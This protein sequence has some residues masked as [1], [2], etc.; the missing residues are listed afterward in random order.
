MSDTTGEKEIEEFYTQN[1]DVNYEKFKNI[2]VILRQRDDFQDKIR[3][4]EDKLKFHLENQSWQKRDLVNILSDFL[5][6]MHHNEVG[7]SLDDKM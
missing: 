2:G 3:T 4:F 5:P 1:D 7:K 6:E